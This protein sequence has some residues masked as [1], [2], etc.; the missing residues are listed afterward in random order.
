MVKGGKD[1]IKVDSTIHFTD[2]ETLKVSSL[3]KNK[4]DMYGKAVRPCIHPFDT[5]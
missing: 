1:R 5:S 3:V 2:H 4:V